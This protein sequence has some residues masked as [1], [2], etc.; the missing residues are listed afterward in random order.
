MKKLLAVLGCSVVL[1]GSVDVNHASVSELSSL[2]G[3]GEKK[4]TR[5][6]Q[7]IKKNG[8]FKTKE[9]L[10]IVKGIGKKTILKNKDDIKIIPCK[11]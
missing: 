7:Y 1:F 11:R 9:Q 6:V 10:S 5:I 4:A 2:H 3:I 8:C